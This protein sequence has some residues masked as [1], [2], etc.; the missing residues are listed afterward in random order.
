M[1]APR[2]FDH[3]E[4]RRLRA[5]GLVYAAIAER[6]GVSISAVRVA[7]DEEAWAE[8]QEAK[9]RWREANH[10]HVN[11]YHRAWAKRRRAAA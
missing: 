1:S 2:R 6:L 10:E 3:D 5:G 7:C 4:A 8:T 11:A 9:R